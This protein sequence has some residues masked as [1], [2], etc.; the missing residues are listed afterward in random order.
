MPLFPYNRINVVG[1][2]GSGKSMLAERIAVRLNLSFIE[3][4]A[5]YWRPNWRGTPDEEFI[6]KVKDAIRKPGWVVAGN[7]SRVRH[8]I[9]PRAEVVVWLDYAFPLVFWRLFK[10]TVRRSITREKL[11]NTNVESFWTHL[12][13]WS[14]DSLFH[15]LI[16]TYW[17]RK[18]EYPQLFAQPAYTH[19]KVY[20]FNKPEEADL[21]LASL[22]A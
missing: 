21:W 4:D 15:W 20:K 22:S 5:L 10:R 11:W 14:D 3:L 9:W 12:K 1:T 8:I 6:P 17:R 2:T 18:R 16:Q 13:L 7:Y 19:L